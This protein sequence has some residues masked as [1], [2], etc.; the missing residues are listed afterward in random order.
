MSGLLFV[1]SKQLGLECVKRV[2]E[3][4][5][6]AI[7]GVLTMDDRD[8]ARSTHDDLAKF[9]SGH[10]IPFA[11]A[12]DRQ[13][14]EELFRDFAPDLCLVVGWYWLVSTGALSAVPRGFLGIHNSLLPKY[15][16][17]APL[18]WALI[19]GEPLVGVSLFSFTPEMDEGE[20]W[21]QRTVS[22]GPN[23][24]IGEVLGRLERE[25]LS[26]L[27]EIW[28]AIVDGS[29]T[30]TPQDPCEATYA[31]IRTAEDGLIDWTR[32]ARRVHDF[33][34]AQ[35]EPYPGAFSFLDGSEKLTIW[36]ARPLEVPYSGT[37]GQVGRLG[38]EG[39]VV[40]CGD[41]RPLLV[42][43]VSKDDGVRVAADQVLGSMSMRLRSC[44]EG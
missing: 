4:T 28:P 22:V 6:G 41:Q 31:S 16:G 20:V 14:S 43:E 24:R 26:M 9:A 17:A 40:I 34:R 23:E 25:T 3:L 13:H 33:I 15:R 19:N 18:V 8:D 32:P 27:G 38:R 1:G 35:S 11:V 2:H 39:V 10:G 21:G 30:P 44:S 5:P 36:R 37:P 12:E 42:E 7:C 29:A